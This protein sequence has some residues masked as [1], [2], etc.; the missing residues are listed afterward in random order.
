MNRQYGWSGKILFID[1]SNGTTRVEPTDQYSSFIGGR[2]INQWLLFNLVEKN[3]DALD[4]G[5]VIILGAGPMVGALVPSGSRLAVDYKNVLTEGVGSGNSGGRFAAEMK[6]AGYDH[7]VIMGKAARPTYI[8]IEDDNV[9]FRDAS[10][11]WGQGTWETENII[12]DKENEWALSTLTI[13][14]AGENLVKFACIIGDKGRAVGYGGGGAVMGSKNLKAIAVR[15]RNTAVKVASPSE[16]MKRVRTFNKEIFRKSSTVEIHRKGGTLGAY[17]LPGQNRPHGVRN[18]N[19]E[20]WSDEAIK[21]VTREKFDE[22]LVRRHA[23]FGCPVY[24]SGIYEIKGI[25]C[26]GIQANS[27]RAF[28]SNVDV[29]RAEDVLYAHALCNKYGLDTDQ[30][31]AAIAWAI[32]CFEKGIIDKGDTDGLK[33]KFGD[34]NCVIQLIQK[35]AA[36]EGFGHLLAMGVHEASEILGHGSRELALLVKKNSAM[37]AGMRSHKAWALGIMTSTKGTGHLRGAPALEFQRLSPETSKKLFDIE[38]INDPTSYK[39]KPA[40]VVWQEKYKGIVDMMGTC[41][42]MSMWMD[43]TLFS[44]EDIADFF[45]DITGKYTSANRLLETGEALQNLERSFN[46]L[47][48]GFGRSDDYPP[49][50]LMEIPV[51]K[52]LYAGE[53]L[54]LNMWNHMLDEYYELHGWDKTTG[55]PTKKRLLALGLDAVV[56][57]LTKN[58]ILL[59]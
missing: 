42:L 1:L 27:L 17:L 8:Y 53:R 14:V 36:R 11:L 47:H 26:E 45:N 40:L 22:F 50:K 39:N 37:E 41:A 59:P 49:R 52:G 30:T 43:E 19:E 5:N 16:F 51:G 31:S 13:G 24:C 46:L 54:D 6:Y 25:T 2:G 55:W 23:C 32:E 9:Y 3:I 33:L 12:K 58:N 34:G 35:I 28:G 18:L 44:P 56:E 4:A 48:S 21:N 10:Y 29:T 20:F 7:I 15:G 38:D 57:K